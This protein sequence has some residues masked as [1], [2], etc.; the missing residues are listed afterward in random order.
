MKKLMLGLVLFSMI[1]C[2][3]EVAY[4][5]R[6]ISFLKQEIFDLK[7]NEAIN[8]RELSQCQRDLSE[9]KN[10][11]N[12]YFLLLHSKRTLVKSKIK[13]GAKFLVLGD[14]NG[15]EDRKRQLVYV[16]GGYVILDSNYSSIQMGKVKT[17]DEVYEYMLEQQYVIVE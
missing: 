14:N 17:L 2:D 11:L 5:E 15:F 4:N 12:G 9:N 7:E 16:D 10:T 8:R 1:G 6:D 3:D 13:V